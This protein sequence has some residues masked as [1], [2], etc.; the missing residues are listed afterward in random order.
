MEH[1]EIRFINE[2]DTLS[3]ENI[4]KEVLQQEFPHYSPRLRQHFSESSYK[5][6]MLSLP[7]KVGAFDGDNIIGFLLANPPYGGVI[8]V[9]WI[10]VKKQYQGKGVGKKLLEFIENYAEEQ[11]A[12]NIFLEAE[13][14]KKDYY[15]Q[16]GYT[17][18][19]FNEK[20]WYGLSTH[21]LKKQLREP[22]ED[23]FLT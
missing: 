10:G 2:N 16:R 6:A 20:G 22:N 14:E 9:Q 18:F 13:E 15:V 1:S 23:L 5:D 7:L 12:H 21:L 17:I 4:Y 11:G 19:G 3:L 8:F